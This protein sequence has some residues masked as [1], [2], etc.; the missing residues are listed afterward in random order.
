MNDLHSSSTDDAE[1]YQAKNISSLSYISEFF[2]ALTNADVDGR[3][4]MELLYDNT[5]LDSKPHIKSSIRYLN[6]NPSLSFNEI[7]AEA[8]CVILAGGTM[9]PFHL[10]TQQLFP[11]LDQTQLTTLSLPHIIADE[12]ILTVTLC[13][14][15]TDTP[16]QFNYDGRNNVSQ[17]DELGRIIQNLCNIVPDGIV[18]FFPSYAYEQQLYEHWKNSGVLQRIAAK[19]MIFRETK[20]NNVDNILQSYTACIA[21]FYTSTSENNTTANK[22]SSFEGSFSNR[23][24]TQTGALLCSIVGGKMS[25]GINFS[26]ELAR[27]VCMIGLPYPNPHDPQLKEKMQFM[28]INAAKQ[29]QQQ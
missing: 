9:K 22:D 4:V 29:Q 27:C 28:D 26:D 1:D 5:V 10:Y 13:S 12:N 16:L 7:V 8:R 15:P 17:M 3:I 2:L 11:S 23:C 18:I 25:E 21:S 14:G 19:K 24:V 20:T 6:L